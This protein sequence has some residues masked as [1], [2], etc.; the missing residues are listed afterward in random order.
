MATASFERLRVYKLSQTLA[1]QV[2][3]VVGKWGIM[4]RYGGKADG[5]GGQRRGQH[6]RG[7]RAWQLSRQSTF[8]GTAKVLD[9]TDIGCEERIGENFFP[10]RKQVLKPLVDSLGPQL[11]AYLKSIGP[12]PGDK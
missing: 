4:C 12:K 9:E 6:S 3:D 8:C 2:W 11:N 10:S 5:K 7:L 1:D